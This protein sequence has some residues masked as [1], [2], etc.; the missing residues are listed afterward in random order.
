MTH[1]QRTIASLVLFALAGLIVALLEYPDR[2]FGFLEN[3]GVQ[4]QAEEEDA[5]E[6][7]EFTQAVGLLREHYVFEDRLMPRKMLFATLAGV[8]ESVDAFLV[9]PSP[10]LTDVLDDNDLPDS[11]T[12]QYRD[13]VIKVPLDRVEDLYSMTWKIMEVFHQFVLP[14]PLVQDMEEGAIGGMVSVL[15]PHTIYMTQRQYNEMKVSTQGAFGGLGIVISVREGD[16]KVVSVMPDTPASRAGILKGTTS[17]RLAKR[18][19][20]T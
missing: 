16:L 20:S 17:F 4:G 3:D 1:Q 18:A 5:L 11:V 12:V 2:G 19:R 14:V 7:V 8:E 15:D 13:K 9:T 6:L 10:A